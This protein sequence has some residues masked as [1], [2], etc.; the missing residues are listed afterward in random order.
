MLAHKLRHRFLIPSEITCKYG[1]GWL[2]AGAHFKDLRLMHRTTVS[3]AAA[4]LAFAWP[5]FAGA[6]GPY[7]VDDAPIVDPGDVQVE[8]WLSRNVK[9]HDM[10]E[11]T[12][13]AY[14]VLPDAEL[15]IEATHDEIMGDRTDTIAPQLK[16]A[17]RK[18]EEDQ[19]ITSSIVV[20]TLYETDGARFSGA[21]AYIPSTL[22]INENFEVSADLGWQYAQTQSQNSV[23]WGVGDV[24]HATPVWSFASEIFGSDTNRPGFQ[25]GPRAVIDNLQLDLVYGQN[26][27]GDGDHT[28]TAGFTLTL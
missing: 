9:Q 17:W 19:H 13:A 3:R 15:T 1:T 5:H 8:G 14:Q 23:T 16:Y 27:F 6:T 25:F 7:V 20:G 28:L 12:D 18:G 4:L 24:Y 11:G 2:H 10:L 26:V 22:V 21:F